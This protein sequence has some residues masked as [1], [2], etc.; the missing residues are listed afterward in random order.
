MSALADALGGAL[1]R[2][3]LCSPVDRWVLP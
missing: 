3:S 2:A 1:G